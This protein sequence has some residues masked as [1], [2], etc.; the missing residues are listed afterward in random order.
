[1]MFSV[2]A[3]AQEKE[4]S[5]S[6]SSGIISAFTDLDPLQS[7]KA[8]VA[9]LVA[10][11]TGIISDPPTDPAKLEAY[12]NKVSLYTTAIN[13][14]K[15][16]SE[17]EKD[18]FA[19]SDALNFLKTVVE[20]EGYLIKSEYDK[21]NSP[22]LSAI[23]ARV[24]AQAMLT[25]ILGPHATRDA[26]YTL[27]EYFSKPFKGTLK[28][29]DAIDYKDAD[30]AAA[31][32]AYKNAYAA[33]PQL[34]RAYCD[35][36][37]PTF[38]SFGQ[39]T[40][41][42]SGLKLVKMLAKNDV[43]L[44]PFTETAPPSAGTA[45]KVADYA[46][47]ATDPG[48]L[49]AVA[50]YL[51]KQKLVMSFTERQTNHAIMATLRAMQT[52]AQIAPEY[53]PL[54]N[55]YIEMRDAF[56]GF[57]QNHTLEPVIQAIKNHE[58]LDSFSKAVSV[59]WNPKAVHY[60]Y[61]NSAGTAYT[62]TSFSYTLLYTECV[63]KQDFALV[64]L[65]ENYIAGVNLEEVNNGTILEA[66]A[67][68]AKVRSDLKKDINASVMEKYNQI[69]ARYVPTAKNTASDYDF[70]QEI[71]AFKPQE[72]M[73]T[74]FKPMKSIISSLINGF[75]S[76]AGNLL[77]L[78]YKR[79]NPGIQKNAPGSLLYTNKNI[80]LILPLYDTL[81]KTKIM[82]D[83]SST[84]QINVG[85]WIG[86]FSKPSTLIS[87]LTEE[88]YASINS[89]IQQ[90]INILN[91]STELY[92]ALEYENG[93]FGFEDG[94][95]E[96]FQTALAAVLRPLV[97][98]LQ[99]GYGLS[100]RLAYMPNHTSANGDFIYGSYDKLVPLLEALGLR[101]VLS[102]EEY[103]AGYYDALANGIGSQMDALISP[104]LNNIINLID[105]LFENPLKT[106]LD[107]L[108]R[109]SNCINSGYLN[110]SFTG[111]LKSTQLLG[112]IKVDLSEEAI[113]GMISGK[114]FGFNLGKN[115]KM[116]LTLPKLNF[117]DIG[118][119]GKLVLAQSK[120]SDFMYR[121][122]LEAERENAFIYTAKYLLTTLFSMKI[123]K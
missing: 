1:M 31:L 98:F 101:D 112:G 88:R 119:C 73:L 104:V 70:A 47:G 109:A 61:L 41:G 46:M 23:D 99:N 89:K 10:D 57:N 45:P 53:A 97:N 33:A 114:S 122:A 51:P 54:M 13:L 82:V 69:L 40:S 93:D 17:A 74:K 80:G 94:D 58:E 107:L 3:T 120:S 42:D 91:D 76:L 20:R 32:L 35:G 110:S 34:V 63:K 21:T 113:D 81:A 66:K 29:S 72:I 71:A 75:N 77:D 121:P 22:K 39:T 4:H 102:S 90:G 8:A 11:K 5:P 78:S 103:S 87:W 7:A 62:S 16:L 14:Y 38:I 64:E 83:V 24:Q 115:L 65:F 2:V 52:L 108:V 18:T 56:L 79:S 28:L 111:F 6:I 26:A 116:S 15:P 95:R 59:F 43:D 84:N 19:V 118:Q 68:Y 67:E 100:G 106:G 60:F 25:S 55:S 30:A 49:A 9:A 50:N 92:A 12:N 44:S 37:A 105:D 36:I 48:Y 117:H 27:G 123:A 86:I 96:G 85:E